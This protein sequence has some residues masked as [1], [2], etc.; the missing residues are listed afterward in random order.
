MK[1]SL[2]STALLS[3]VAIYFTSQVLP[4]SVHADTFSFSQGIE[5]DADFEGA[6]TFETET[7]P[8]DGVVLSPSNR[9]A[10]GSFDESVGLTGGQGFHYDDDDDDCSITVHVDTG[11]NT[12]CGLAPGDCEC[13]GYLYEFTVLY[14]GPD[15][16]LGGAY[17]YHDNTY[18]EWSLQNGETYTF[19]V[20]NSNHEGED[21]EHNDPMMWTYDGSWEHYG[22]Y[23]A[24]CGESHIGET[25][26]PFTL[27]GFVDVNGNV[28]G[29]STGCNGVADVTPTSGEAPYTFLW[30][31][32]ATSEDRD[33]LC[34][35]TYHV[36]VT[37]AHGCSGSIDVVVGD[38]SETILVE[39]T[40]GANTTCGSTPTPPET[41]CACEGKMRSFTLEYIG[42]S[43]ATVT[44]YDDDG[45]S[46]ILVAT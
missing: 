17:D 35:G 5:G 11:S 37:D 22:T 40:T 39:V 1:L 41:D 25:Y 12:S 34:T 28:C 6:T 21:H 44:A 15:G 7:A 38:N 30:S 14:T 32:G 18:G 36:T 10:S 46:A 26:G 33:D 3:V 27:I 16:V 23:D 20:S 42:P 24:T 43:G 31:D 45:D 13:H 2:L 8:E 29:G 4:S 19:N 9:S